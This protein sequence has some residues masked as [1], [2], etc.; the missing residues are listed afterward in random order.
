MNFPCPLCGHKRIMEYCEDSTRSYFQCAQCHLVFSNPEKYL[1]RTEEKFI[2]DL[3]KNSVD[4][5]GYRKFL[6]RLLL[7]MSD[8]LSVGAKGLDFGCGPGPALA[9]M[10]DE[11]GFPMEL[12]DVFYHDNKSVLQSKYDFITATEVVEHL[13]QPGEVIRGLWDVLVTGGQLGIMTKLVINQKSFQQWHY[14][15]DPTHVC[16][17]SRHSFEWLASELDASLDF[18]GADV[19]IMEKNNCTPSRLV[20]KTR[21]RL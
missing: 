17:F 4:D 18:F 14:K 6:S 10:F 16:F 3:H 1:S 5:T 19:I 2:Y 20:V 15:N 11:A 7:P 21:H 9:S 13:F 8:R 12:Y